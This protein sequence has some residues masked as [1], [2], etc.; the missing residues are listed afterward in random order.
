MRLVTKFALSAALA[1]LYCAGPARAQFAVDIY[2]DE[3]GHGRLTNTAGFDATLAFTIGP[4]TGPGGLPTTLHY[5]LLDPPGL[6]AGDLLVSES[7][8][9]LDVIRFNVLPTGGELVFY[10]DDLDGA[11]SLADT[12]GP[13][14]S[15]YPNNLTVNEINGSVLYTPTAGQPGFVTGAGGPVTYHILSDASVPE[16]GAAALLFGLATTAVGVIYR[17][18]RA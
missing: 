12:P 15:F 9:I 13:P 5:D 17:K 6:I 14:T 10:S 1:L 8:Q 4:D 2:V 16:P 7:G 11:D 3:N 18:R